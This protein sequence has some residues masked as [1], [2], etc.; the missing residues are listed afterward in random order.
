PPVGAAGDAGWFALRT[1]CSAP[2]V[3]PGNLNPVER[4]GVGAPARGVDAPS[5][6]F[7]YASPRP[8]ATPSAT[9]RAPCLARWTYD[10][11]AFDEVSQ[12]LV[13]RMS[14]RPWPS[15]SESKYFDVDDACLNASFSSS[16]S[17]RASRMSFDDW[18]PNTFADVSAP[19]APMTP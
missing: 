8:G 18:S 6:Y 19:N 3:A 1:S 12:L 2:P 10:R 13:F 5:R 16:F 17:E 7:K 11:M 9:A 14:F 4:F 15:F